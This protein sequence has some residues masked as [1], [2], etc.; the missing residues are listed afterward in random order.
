MTVL[1]AYLLILNVAAFLA[2][3][4]DKKRAIQQKRFAGTGIHCN[5][6]IPP[7]MLRTVCRC[8]PEAEELLRDAFDALG[9]SARAYDRLLKTA[10]TIADLAGSELIDADAIGEAI[11][12]RTLDRKYWNN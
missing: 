8:T 7:K 6:Q 2:M 12:Y 1:F 11:Q 4:A 3:G 9:L 5:A 10:R